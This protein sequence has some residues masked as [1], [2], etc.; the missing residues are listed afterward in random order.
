MKMS[1]ERGGQSMR[2]SFVEW[3]EGLVAGDAAW[4]G[5][6]K[7]V[8]AAA[9]EILVTN[10]L[11]FGPWLAASD[12]YDAAQAMR[13]VEL[14]DAGLQALAEL[15]VPVVLSSRPVPVSGKLAN[16]AFALIKGEYRALH[17]KH[18]FPAEPG[19]YETGWFHTAVPG[20]DI[21]V[22]AGL[23]IGVLLC[24]ELM[25]NER[26]RAYGASGVDLIIA[27]RAS[28]APA[29]EWKIAG[30]MAALVSGSYVVSSNRVGSG[31]E[32]PEFGGCGF[33]FA[34]GGHLIAETSADAPI[35]SFDLDPACSS[36]AKS[37]YPC[38]VSDVPVFA[39]H[40]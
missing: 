30:A 21:A 26:A 6:R 19:W 25:F 23:R 33:A 14:H 4:S 12:R 32:G 40:G 16:E 17:Q 11:P 31:A 38:Y 10:E 2:V 15:E 29:D 39:E 35:M 22:E 37:Q 13:S 9:P 27:P 1:R 34:P 8:W 7:A 3:P 20:F 36:A 24:T 18:Y 28:G 5:I